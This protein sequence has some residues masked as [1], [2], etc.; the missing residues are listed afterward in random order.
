MV[1]AVP[2]NAPVGRRRI[3]FKSGIGAGGAESSA[4]GLQEVPFLSFQRQRAVREAREV[5]GRR[6][7]KPLDQGG[8]R[9]CFTTAAGFNPG[10]RLVTFATHPKRG[11]GR[12]VDPS[13]TVGEPPVYTVSLNAPRWVKTGKTESRLPS[14]LQ[15]CRGSRSWVCCS[16]S[17]SVCFSLLLALWNPVQD[18]PLHQ[19]AAADRQCQGP[20]GVRSDGEAWG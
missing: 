1:A 6:G 3:R 20:L 4:V 9:T 2:G 13:P 16:P 14:S 10:C 5:R 7:G 12:Q 8:K 17:L 18:P 19:P 11:L 15:V